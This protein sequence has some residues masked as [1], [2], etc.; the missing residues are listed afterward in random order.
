M[1][2]YEKYLPHING[3]P[4]LKNYIEIQLIDIIEQDDIIYLKLTYM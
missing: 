4:N 3:S 1:A 2:D